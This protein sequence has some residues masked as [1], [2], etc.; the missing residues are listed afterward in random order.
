MDSS[1]GADRLFWI[2]FHSISKLLISHDPI[3]SYCLD[4]LLYLKEY[5]LL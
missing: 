4:M 5:C 1:A 3:S 2:S